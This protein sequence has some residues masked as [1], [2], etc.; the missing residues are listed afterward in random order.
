MRKVGIFLSLAF[1]AIAFSP[2]A[3]PAGAL[4][5]DDVASLTT[6]A[7]DVAVPDAEGAVDDTVETV[8]ETLEP[9]APVTEVVD[10]TVKKVTGSPPPDPGDIVDP[11]EDDGKGE[12]DSDPV[13]HERETSGDDSRGTTS[14]SSEPAPASVASAPV[15]APVQE[16]PRPAAL[17]QYIAK[18]EAPVWDPPATTYIQNAG[19][20]YSAAPVVEE[21]KKAASKFTL[22]LLQIVALL[23]VVGMLSAEFLY[24]MR[25]ISGGVLRP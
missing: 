16:V 15:A 8:E 24:G 18:T 13:T 23:L 1:L 3:L 5:A 11:P 4:G 17:R 9:A 6:T 21:V 19:S 22:G 2:A 25:R 20:E 12:G 14:D 7:D 10:D